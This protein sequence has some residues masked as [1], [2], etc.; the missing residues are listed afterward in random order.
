MKRRDLIK[1]LNLIPL[2]GGDL[3]YKAQA[4]PNLKVQE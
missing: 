3:A 1:G 4:D 2:A